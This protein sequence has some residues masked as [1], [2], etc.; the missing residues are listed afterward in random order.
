MIW[1]TL[2]FIIAASVLARL[3]HAG[4]PLGRSRV[5]AAARGWG[6]GELPRLLLLLMLLGAILAGA[7]LR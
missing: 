6:L 7:R 3:L 2:G 5:L 4:G 1:A